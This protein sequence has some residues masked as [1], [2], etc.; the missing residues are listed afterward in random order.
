MGAAFCDLLK[1]IDKIIFLKL[2]MPI[3]DI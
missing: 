1:E 3:C 2:E